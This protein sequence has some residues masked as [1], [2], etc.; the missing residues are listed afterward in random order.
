MAIKKGHGI[1]T[2]REVHA[3]KLYLSSIFITREIFKI[4]IAYSS[5]RTAVNCSRKI[6]KLIK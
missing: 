3:M 5:S 2:I 4:R 6:L 1:K